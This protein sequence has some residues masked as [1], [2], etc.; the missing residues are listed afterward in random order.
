VVDD[1][2]KNLGRVVVW[3]ARGVE[4]VEAVVIGGRWAR[5]CAAVLLAMVV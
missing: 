4:G 2:V 1:P 3:V 5:H